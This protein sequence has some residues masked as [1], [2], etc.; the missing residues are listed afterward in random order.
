MGRT[1][2]KFSRGLFPNSLDLNE[3]GFHRHSVSTGYR[4]QF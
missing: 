4:T 1:T 2:G 3:D